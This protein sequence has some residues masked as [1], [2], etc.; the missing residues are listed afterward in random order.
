M[1]IWISETKQNPNTSYGFGRVVEKMGKRYCSYTVR[2]VGAVLEG[3]P[4]NSGSN[5]EE[6]LRNCYNEVTHN[7]D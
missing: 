7:N 6:I 2:Y 1:P 4:P 3:P 5:Y